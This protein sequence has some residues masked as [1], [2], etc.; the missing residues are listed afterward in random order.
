MKHRYTDSD[1]PKNFN[2]SDY[3][4]DNLDLNSNQEIIEKDYNDTI[5]DVMEENNP[6]NPYNDE[7]LTF[8]Y[9]ENGDLESLEATWSEINPTSYGALSPDQLR[10]AKNHCIILI[11]FASRAA[12]RG[13]VY[14]ETAFSLCD[15]YIQRLEQCTSSI[16]CVRLT[17]NA[18]TYYTRLV[19]QSQKKRE[20][21]TVK[22][23]PLIE[24]CLDLIYAHLH[25]N[26]TV[27]FLAD[28]LHTHPNYLSTLFKEKTGERIHQF[29]IRQK[30]VLVE[31]MLTYSDYSLSEIAGYLGFSSQSHLVSVFKK[32]KGLTPGEFRKNVK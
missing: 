20:I 5:F 18:E 17:R 19:Q 23:S 24:A 6:H 21:S 2:L 26:I 1:I 30:I 15:S 32:Y 3:L 27:E 16:D 25:E 10:N 22:T 28:E 4:P 9:I 13:G 11:A 8:S 29:I 12:I 31:N 7:V 14:Y